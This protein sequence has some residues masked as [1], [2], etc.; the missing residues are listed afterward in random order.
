M[1]A[2]S[3]TLSRL[4]LFFFFLN[5]AY[6][7]SFSILFYYFLCIFP[8]VTVRERWKSEDNITPSLR[9]T[10]NPI[11][12]QAQSFLCC[13]FPFY[14]WIK[15]KQPSLLLVKTTFQIF[16]PFAEDL[17]TFTD[18]C[19]LSKTDNYHHFTAAQNQMIAAL[20]SLNVAHCIHLKETNFHQ[21]ASFLQT[22]QNLLRLLTLLSTSNLSAL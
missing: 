5:L 15:C 14:T 7:C 6:F 3:A 2:V 4:K 12:S 20:Y 13:F 1:A 16:C 10:L 11:W 22:H 18:L 19:V 21:C 8:F 9:C 17:P